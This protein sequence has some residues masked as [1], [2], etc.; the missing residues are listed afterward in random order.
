MATVRELFV[1]GLRNAHVM[2]VHA[3]E[4]LERQSERMDQYP[5]LQARIKQ[6]LQE[7]YDQLDRIEI[8]LSACGETTSTLDDMAQPFMADNQASMRSLTDDEVLKNTFANNGFEN[9]EIAAYK[10]LLAMCRSA[11]ENGARPH[12]EASLKEEEEMARWLNQHVEDITND[13]LAKATAATR[14][15]LSAR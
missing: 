10:S 7:T 4:L 2:E 11:Q 1:V 3:R 15:I 6:H 8:C 14:S 13:Y 9:F 5:A 12:L